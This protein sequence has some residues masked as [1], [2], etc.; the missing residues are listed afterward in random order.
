[1]HVHRSWITVGLLVGAIALA[2]CAKTE[3][4]SESSGDAAATLV[5]VENSEPK[6]ILTDRAEGRIGLQLAEIEGA[7]GEPARVAYGAVVYDEDGKTWVYRKTK[8][9]TYRRVP[10]TVA[11]IDGEVVTLSDGPPPG[12]KV[13]TVGTAELSGVEQ[14]IG[15]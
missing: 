7:A 3:E 6:V 5:E 13:V 9:L 14:G 4:S 10:I 15:A 1:M 2:G 8:D 12:T 11:D